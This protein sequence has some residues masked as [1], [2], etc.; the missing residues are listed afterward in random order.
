MLAY[1]L[2]V[3]LFIFVWGEWVLGWFGD[4]FVSGYGILAVLC[5]GQMVIS[6]T[7]PVGFLM[8]MTGYQRQAAWVIG[9][10]ALLNIVLNALLISLMG[11][12]GAAV[13]TAIVISLRSIVLSVLVKKKL[14]I[15]ATALPV[16]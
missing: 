4:A 5:L 7:G 15:S 3:F 13:A 6:L 10:T 9:A 11:M 2:P 14:R 16:R 1:S 8:S 12:I